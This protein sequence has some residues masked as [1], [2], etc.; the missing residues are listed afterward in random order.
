[1]WLLSTTHHLQSVWRWI[2]VGQPGDEVVT[3]PMTCTPT[4]HQFWSSLPP[5]FADVQMDSGNI[6]PTD[7][8]QRI[9]EDQSNHLHPLLEFRV[10]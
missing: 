6:D 8:E 3:T 2:Y 9:T 4:N 7:V 5:V 10:I 1:M